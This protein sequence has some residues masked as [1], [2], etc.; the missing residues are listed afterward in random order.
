MYWTNRLELIRK[1]KTMQTKKWYQSQ[2]IW[3]GII[4]FL[5]FIVTVFGLDLDQGMITELITRLAELVG[6]IMVIL[7]RLNAKTIIE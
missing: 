7:G 3:G 4:A 1:E 2:T 6:L 5:M